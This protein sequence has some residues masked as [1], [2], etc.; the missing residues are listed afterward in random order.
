MIFTSKEVP[1]GGEGTP[2]ELSLPGGIDL[3]GN[4]PNEAPAQA[5]FDAEIALS[6]TVSG[7]RATAYL[8]I[9]AALLIE[10]GD[11]LSAERNRQQAREQ[12]IESNDIFRQF[13]EERAAEVA[14]IA[15]EAFR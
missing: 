10:A 2:L 1:P 9:N 12:F 7:W 15:A 14:H 11:F 3:Q 13:R 4:S 5:E 6:L 8:L